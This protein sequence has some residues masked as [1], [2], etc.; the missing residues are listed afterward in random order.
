MRWLFKGFCL[1][2]FIIKK[3]TVFKGLILKYEG[4]MKTWLFNI[5]SNTHSLS[6]CVPKENTI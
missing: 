6:D 2:N 3:Y 5:I 4:V 1:W